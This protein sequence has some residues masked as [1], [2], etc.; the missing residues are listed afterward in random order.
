VLVP[1]GRFELSSRAA[2]RFEEA[3]RLRA[4]LAK[5]DAEV[6]RIEAKLGNAAFV[7]RAPAA[8]VDKE[9]AK[10]AG[11]VADR[12]ELRGRLDALGQG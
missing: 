5:L 8:I 6:T 4:Q 9:R 2:D 12:D 3:A 10:L 11:F 7:E 1:G